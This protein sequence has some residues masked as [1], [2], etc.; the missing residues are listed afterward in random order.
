MIFITS[1]VIYELFGRIWP[2]LPKLS[3]PPRAEVALIVIPIFTAHIINIWLYALIYL[4]IENVSSMGE[5]IGPEK[6]IS[7]SLDSFFACLYFS[8]TTYTT[9]GF[10]DFVATKALRLLSATEAL[11]GLVLMGWT[12][13]FTYLA[14]EKFWRGKPVRK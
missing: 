2:L 3:L 7:W 6:S 14:M 13:S 12:V 5:I 9:L 11:N 10:G 1:L 4:T 8:G